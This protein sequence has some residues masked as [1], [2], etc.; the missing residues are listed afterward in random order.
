MASE[1]GGPGADQGMGEPAAKMMAEMSQALADSHLHAMG[2]NEELKK[3]QVERQRAMDLGSKMAHMAGAIN[4]EKVQLESHAAQ[5]AQQ[6]AQD[7]AS[8]AEVNMASAITAGTLLEQRVSQAEQRASAAEFKLQ[9]LAQAVQS[10][11]PVVQ[12][13]RA[14]LT[15]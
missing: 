10:E 12:T 1:K 4:E 11:A 5:L 7:Q 6:A 15:N 13:E 9:E 3:A 8:Q 2:L 14:E